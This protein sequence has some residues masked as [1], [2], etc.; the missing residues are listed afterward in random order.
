[1]ASGRVTRA[2][3]TDRREHESGRIDVIDDKGIADRPRQVSHERGVLAA[4][5]QGFSPW[6]HVIIPALHL[7]LKK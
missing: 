7:P 2:N 6:S 4:H 5:R 1:M 3:S